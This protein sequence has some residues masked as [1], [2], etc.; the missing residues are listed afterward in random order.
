M[1]RRRSSRS[2]LD[3]AHLPGL[4]D[5]PTIVA[6][7]AASFLVFVVAVLLLFARFFTP[8]CVLLFLFA[9]FWFVDGRAVGDSVCSCVLSLCLFLDSLQFYCFCC[10]ACFRSVAP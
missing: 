6:G 10:S 9:A 3:V 8:L 2:N 1:E 7:I 4:L 5:V